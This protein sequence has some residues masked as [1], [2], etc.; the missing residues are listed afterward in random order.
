MRGMR[1]DKSEL[2]AGLGS[3][4]TPSGEERRDGVMSFG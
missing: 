2:V 1:A 4:C 3:I